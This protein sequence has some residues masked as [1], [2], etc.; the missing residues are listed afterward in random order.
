MIF[1]I[2]THIPFSVNK[3]NFSF[4]EKSGISIDSFNKTNLSVNIKI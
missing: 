3:S 4:K 1:I 2:F